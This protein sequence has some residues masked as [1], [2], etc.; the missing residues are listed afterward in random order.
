MAE[1]QSEESRFFCEREL[2][3]EIILAMRSAREFMK[4]LGKRKRLFL[5]GEVELR[6]LFSGKFPGASFGFVFANGKKH[7]DRLF[8]RI[9]PSN[10]FY[11]I[12]LGHGCASCRGFTA[13]P[14][15]DM[16]KY[17]RS[18]IGFGFW[19]RIVSDEKFKRVSEIVLLHLLLFLP[20]RFRL[21]GEDPMLVVV[22]GF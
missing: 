17:G 5:F 14:P 13:P 21:V 10:E 6:V 18:C 11:Q 4:K 20:R 22:G 7:V 16:K 12:F 8:G 2:R 9:E 19:W 15:P 1:D 3:C